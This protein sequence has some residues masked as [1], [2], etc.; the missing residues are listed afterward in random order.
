MTLRDLTGRGYGSIK[1]GGFVNVV[2][3]MK[4]EWFYEMRICIHYTLCVM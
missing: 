4:S 3:K 2:W 1:I